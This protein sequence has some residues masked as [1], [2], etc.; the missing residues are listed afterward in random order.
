MTTC[1]RIQ[2]D[3]AGLAALPAA[4][5]ERIAAF[6]HARTCAAC[7]RAL[8]EGVALFALLEL[9]A[10]AEAPGESSLAPAVADIRREL[11]RGPRWPGPLSSTAAVVLSLTAAW[12]LALFSGRRSAVQGHAAISILVAAVAALTTAGAMAL[13]TPLL[14]AIPLTS[15]L[16]SA[17][18]G[19]A[20]PLEASVGVHCLGLE[21]AAA[22]L[23]LAA[24]FLLARRGAFRRPS[25]ALAAAAGGGALAG[26]AALEVTCHALRTHAHLLTF[27]TG[28]V[29][30]G[31]L[32]ALL[33]GRR[34]E[35]ARG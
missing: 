6:E 30:L 1:E 14:A 32:F 31:L 23:P 13:W 28:G 15:L 20:G 12:L 21:L 3:A 5:P 33:L 17:A 19:T 25:F 8:A 26:Q 4:D 24:G 11:A 35:G 22:V 2:A 10:P 34:F 16:A 7:A 18:L 27:H 29:A 9:G